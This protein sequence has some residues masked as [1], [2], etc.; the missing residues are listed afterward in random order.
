M[1]LAPSLAAVILAGGA[2]SRMGAPKALLPWKGEPV[3]A[4][5]TR[6][7]A[8]ELG[9]SHL[10]LGHNSIAIHGVLP[11]LPRVHIIVNAAPER[12]MLSSL[13]CG[14]R[15]VSPAA[16][17]IFFLPVDYP[18]ISP[19]TIAAMREAWLAAPSAQVVLPRSAGRRGHPVL[20]SRAVAN[21]LLRL[22][23]DSAAHKVI[24]ADESRI[25]YVDV[26]DDAIHRDADDAASFDELQR[27]FGR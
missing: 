26:A 17:G 10:V 16:E 20:I 27:E 22:S 6:I 2:S 11:R 23:S 3:A 15:A 25:R 9:S 7:F 5:L 18:A 14:L 1:T 4:R 12:G 8:E 21:E 24:R 13:Q 19:H